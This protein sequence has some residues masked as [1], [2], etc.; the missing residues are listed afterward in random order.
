MGINPAYIRE[1]EDDDSV[2][3]SV[4]YDSS[5]VIPKEYIREPEDFDQPEPSMLEEARRLI[6]PSNMYE[7]LKESQLMEEERLERE[8]EKNAKLDMQRKITAGRMDEIDPVALAEYK[9]DLELPEA[10]GISKEKVPKGI[11]AGKALAYR[12]EVERP[13]VAALPEGRE[14]LTAEGWMPSEQVAKL[15]PEMIKEPDEVEEAPVVAGEEPSPVPPEVMGWE[16]VQIEPE[17]TWQG[18]IRRPY[19][20][21]AASLGQL[22]VDAT[23]SAMELGAKVPTP[24]FVKR[25]R[26]T[27]GTQQIDDAA[28]QKLDNIAV[29][30][31]LY[32]KKIAD[33]TRKEGGIGAE[34]A[35]A[36]TDGAAQT[37]VVLA[38]AGVLAPVKLAGQVRQAVTSAARFGGVMAALTPGT[39]EERI[40]KGIESAAFMM[41]PIAATK[42]ASTPATALLI[43]TLLNAGVDTVSGGWKDAI[44][45]AV[46]RAEERGEP[47]E[48]KRELLVTLTPMVLNEGIFGVM[49]GVA[50]L[51]D[52]QKRSIFDAI[53]EMPLEHAEQLRHTEPKKWERFLEESKKIEGKEIEDL[54]KKEA[55]DAIKEGE[56]KKGGER[57]YTGVPRGEDVSAYQAEVREGEGGRAGGGGGIT[58]GRIEPQGTKPEV[59]EGKA[60][61]VKADEKAAETPLERPISTEPIPIRPPAEAKPPE[62]MTP[63]E[64]AASVT[65][66]QYTDMVLRQHQIGPKETGRLAEQDRSIVSGNAEEAHA[67][68]LSDMVKQRKP[69]NAVSWDEYNGDLDVVNGKRVYTPAGPPPGYVREGDRYVFK[70]EAK[71][72]DWQETPRGRSIYKSDLTQETVKENNVAD[73]I[74]NA[75]SWNNLLKAYKSF[76]ISLYGKDSGRAKNAEKEAIQQPW[77]LLTAHADVMNA[78]SMRSITLRKLADAVF[79]ET[80]LPRNQ[81]GQM[82]GMNGINWDKVI[83]P[84]K[85]E[86]GTLP[87][88]AQ[89]KPE[90]SSKLVEEKIEKPVAPLTVESPEAAVMQGKPVKLPIGTIKVKADY[91]DGKTATVNAEDIETLARTGEIKKLTPLQGKDKPVAGKIIVKK[92]KT[93]PEKRTLAEKK[94]QAEKGGFFAAM[95]ASERL[96]DIGNALVGKTKE[97]FTVSEGREPELQN[98]VLDYVSQGLA[99]NVR[100]RRIGAN[101]SYARKKLLEN[102]HPKA[103]ESMIQDVINGKRTPDEFA[104]TFGLDKNNQVYL[105]L[106]HATETREKLSLKLAEQL[107]KQGKEDLADNVEAHANNYIT[108]FY[109]RWIMGDDYIPNPDDYRAAIDE[110]TSKVGDELNKF[111]KSSKKFAKKIGATQA[112]EYLQTGDKSLIKNADPRTKKIAELL[113]DRYAQ[114]REQID[115]MRPS[116]KAD[117]KNLIQF[118]HNVEALKTAGKDMVDYLLYH[119]EPKTM[120]HLAKR[121]L[122]PV[123]RRLYGEITSTPEAMQRTVEVQQQLLRGM[124]LTN[125]ISEEGAGKWWAEW[126]NKKKGLTV[127]LKGT[128]FGK[129]NQKFV[130]PNT[131]RVLHYSEYVA[132]QAVKKFVEGYHSIIRYQRVKQ[133]A[134]SLP[135]FE[136]NQITNI[137]SFPLANGDLLISPLLGSKA[138]FMKHFADGIKFVKDM[139]VVESGSAK[140]QTMMDTLE[141][142]A[143]L[144]VYHLTHSSVLTDVAQGLEGTSGRLSKLNKLEKRMGE[145]YAW[146]DFPAKYASFMTQKQLGKSDAEA[147]RHV[148][149]FY[150]HAS[151]LPRA[152]KSLAKLPLADFPTFY[153][154]STRLKINA[155]LYAAESARRGDVRPLIGFMLSNAQYALQSGSIVERL[156]KVFSDKDKKLPQQIDMEQLNAIKTFQP[157]YWQRKPL[158]AAWGKDK[159]GQPVIDYVV[160]ANITG[161]PI[162]DAIVGAL[163]KK[164]LHEFPQELMENFLKTGMTWN[165]VAKFL[166]GQEIGFAASNYKQ[167]GAIDWALSEDPRRWKMIRGKIVDLLM[168]SGLPIPYR[169]VRAI[170]RIGELEKDEKYGRIKPSEKHE[171]MKDMLYSEVLPIKS[172]TI[173]ADIAR[174]MILNT[175]YPHIKVIRDVK[176]EYPHVPLKEGRLGEITAAERESP[177]WQERQ[178]VLNEKYELLSNYVKQAR[179]AFKG[180]LNEDL[181]HAILLEGLTP[182]E[183]DALMKNNISKIPDYEARMPRKYFPIL[184]EKR[185]KELQDSSKRVE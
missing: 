113:H 177:E 54:A 45:A 5:Y 158:V 173:T 171:Q 125:R 20:S 40:K 104:K 62:K 115:D 148:Q 64:R 92:V 175:I 75:P 149:R 86:P 182:L 71:P 116:E 4:D 60:E 150:Q 128:R 34:L 63:E 168:E 114:L 105:N 102:F 154:D 21:L 81:K 181:L 93:T 141:K 46:D 107:R 22:V 164:K 68:L 29:D 159:E 36:I 161:Y 31:G 6:A 117:N 76:I 174:K 61:G 160:A 156:S 80:K 38:G 85:A 26:E 101:M 8:R 131:A 179:I 28:K 165:Q 58:G 111:E 91:T 90:V 180:L 134:F 95:P 144:D 110:A 24:R 123:F 143:K 25:L 77:K 153:M 183:S 145:I 78:R 1:P 37:A 146:G 127:K 88:S 94:Q 137:L 3:G 7:R 87:P 124:E 98:I 96:R 11:Y 73:K 57:E 99:D 163:Q 157:D 79:R 19:L 69:V 16:G 83:T 49:G 97:W 120:N 51:N 132:G 136:R 66:E 27:I 133:L 43:N 9:D 65:P 14:T 106:K 100:E 112:I 39:A 35:Q 130:S 184:L 47:D 84:T 119:G 33:E 18:I 167:R 17:G 176:S 151:S 178:I 172:R 129:L 103:V 30:L 142:F 122:G 108:R 55:E 32:R 121:V 56:I 15:P 170:K 44:N 147:A 155:A 140:Y 67:N 12:E 53:K 10:P 42:W 48:W 152:L 23:R 89:P 50:K 138:N 166:Y 72:A 185:K 70:G 52:V 13:P 109:E 135:T 74:I 126:P 169:Q 59:G 139:A 118:Q 41:T 2:V 82:R 162:D